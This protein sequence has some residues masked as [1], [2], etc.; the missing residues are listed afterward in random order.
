MDDDIQDDGKTIK[1]KKEVQERLKSKGPVAILFFMRSCGHCKDTK[2]V[3]DAV[4]KDGIMEME[5]VSSDNTPDE[6]GISGFP[7]MV[8]VKDGK[9]A[10]RF[11]GSVTDKAELKKKLLG[12][13]SG[14]RHRRTRSRKTRRRTIRKSR[15]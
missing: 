11:D 5:N 4:S 6:L 15:K 8:V 13:K 14:G 1:T 3:W 10:N 7:T 2:P 12:S 9:I